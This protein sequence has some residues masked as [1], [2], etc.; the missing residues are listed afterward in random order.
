[1]W[2]SRVQR[3]TEDTPI[4]Q[5]RRLI[6]WALVASAVLNIGF[7]VLLLTRRDS[8]PAS[9]PA[10]IQYT[11]HD[12]ERAREVTAGMHRTEVKTLLGEPAAKEFS[13]ES[14]EWHYCRTGKSVDEYIAV[15]FQRE[16]VA[17]L[18][19]YT[20]TVFDLAMHYGEGLSSNVLS[21]GG[22]GDCRLTVRWGT[23]N[24]KEP[25][26]RVQQVVATA[27]RQPASAP[28]TK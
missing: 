10:P 16:K 2:A 14:E 26:T 12:L 19:Y 8:P 18:Q 3:K 27:S 1:M 4:R 15:K 13:L 24:R 5:R 9:L 28:T 7:G 11:Q 25:D 21:R 23:Y 22:F 17:A 6:Y 20:V